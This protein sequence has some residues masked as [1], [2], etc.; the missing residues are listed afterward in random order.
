MQ[1]NNLPIKKMWIFGTVFFAM[2]IL[3]FILDAYIFHITKI[4][5]DTNNFPNRLAIMKVRFNKPLD[6]KA[7][8]EQHSKDAKSVVSSSFDSTTNLKIDNK[9]LTIEFSTI[10][11][12]GNQT[13]KLANITSVNGDTL[14]QTININLKDIPYEKMTAEEKSIFD[15]VASFGEDVKDDPVV[16]ALPYDNDMYKI[17]YY[18]S[19]GEANQPIIIRITM[20]FFKPG[21]NALP[22]TNEELETYYSQLR[23]YRT[24]AINYLKSKGIRPEKYVMEY[25]EDDL[26]NEFPQGLPKPTPTNSPG[27]VD[28]TPPVEL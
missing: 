13:I 6:S 19:P 17:A 25:S 2:I 24:E 5:P 27:V 4:V 1:L 21:D 20:R 9:E 3:Y 26:V 8:Q 11:R 23:K 16:A 12:S 10:P 22:A 14:S 15:D 18:S 7:I 28:A